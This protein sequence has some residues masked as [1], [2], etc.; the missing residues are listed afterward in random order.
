[1]KFFIDT[2]DINE[3]KEAFDVG[4]LDGVTTNPTL[5]ARTGRDQESVVREICEFVKGPVSAEV[6]STDAKNMIIEGEKLAK[7]AP[8]IAVKLPVTVDGLKACKALSEQNIMVNVTLI[9]TCLQSLMAAKAGA[10][11]VSPFIARL[12]NVCTDGTQM[13]AETREIF[14]NYGFDTEIIAASI[15]HPLHVKDAAEL[16][17]DISTI[18]FD[19]FNQLIQHPLTDI[20]L[21]SFLADYAKSKK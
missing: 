17:I 13:I 19:V 5:I 12:D 4:I 8:N 15:R 9:F 14:D 1:M 10:T 21:E 7:I 11:F 16:G 20:G 2:A 3:I 18:P 6:I